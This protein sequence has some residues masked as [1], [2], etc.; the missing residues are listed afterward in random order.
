M[1]TSLDDIKSPLFWRAVVAEFIGTAF[2]VL[3]GCGSCTAWGSDH[4]PSMEHIGLAFG[5]IVGAMV[6]S[7]AHVSGGHINPAVTISMLITHMSGYYVVSEQHM[8]AL[9]T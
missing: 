7:I 1:A 3:F 6:W 5:L 2:L 8:L 9:T 4:Q